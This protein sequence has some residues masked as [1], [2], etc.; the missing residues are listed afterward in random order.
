[1]TVDNSYSGG[2]NQTSTITEESDKSYKVSINE[3]SQASIGDIDVAMLSYDTNVNNVDI[4]S[5]EFSLPENY[6]GH[7]QLKDT[8][9]NGKIACNV[10]I[11]SGGLFEETFVVNMKLKTTSGETLTD[12]VTLTIEF[13]EVLFNEF[14]LTC[15]TRD[16]DDD[17]GE[18]K[19]T[20]ENTYE[21]SVSAFKQKCTLKTGSHMAISRIK[22]NTSVVADNSNVEITDIARKLD[23]I[24]FCIKPKSVGTS[25]V[26]VKSKDD[27]NVEQSVSIT[28]TITE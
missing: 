28:V 5:V 1:M 13:A 11:T 27:S 26:T 3:T 8:T 25:V 20:G 21:M 23:R 18:I 10:G 17:R 6:Q 14:T 22:N 15:E 2:F 9:S 16:E 4:Q 24:E 19:L 12:N 7:Y